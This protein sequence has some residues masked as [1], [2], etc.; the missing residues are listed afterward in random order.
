M[1]TS[2]ISIIIFF[3]LNIPIISFEEYRETNDNK[4]KPTLGLIENRSH[5]MVPLGYGVHDLL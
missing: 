4:T 1:N 5:F 3:S 2:F